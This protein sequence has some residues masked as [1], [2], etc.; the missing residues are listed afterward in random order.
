M[1]DL[2]GFLQGDQIPSRRRFDG[3]ARERVPGGG[4]Y[5]I[6]DASILNHDGID[7]VR[8]S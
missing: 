3:T 7:G 4:R 8:D 6:S 2:A 5:D 1:M